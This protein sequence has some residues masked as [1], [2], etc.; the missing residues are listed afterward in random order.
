MQM[1]GL[2]SVN[3]I[4]I[5]K[6]FS[7]PIMIALYTLNWILRSSEKKSLNTHLD[8]PQHALRTVFQR[9]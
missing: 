6:S 9:D 2:F 5:T 8:P 1:C 3:F 4:R 7:L